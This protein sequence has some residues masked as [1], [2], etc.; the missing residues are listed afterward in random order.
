VPQSAL[1][2]GRSRQIVKEG[3]AREKAAAR[4]K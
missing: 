2:I 1:A 3:W 4:Q